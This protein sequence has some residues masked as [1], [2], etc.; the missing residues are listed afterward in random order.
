MAGKRRLSGASRRAWRLAVAG[1]DR[2]GYPVLFTSQPSLSF[3]R[4]TIA[5]DC[6]M[7]AC[8]LLSILRRAA[9]S[10]LSVPADPACRQ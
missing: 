6:C 1:I 10:T 4:R 8:I 3:F 5:M 7:T 2:Y 9:A